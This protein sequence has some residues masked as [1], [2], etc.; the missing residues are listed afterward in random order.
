MRAKVW[1]FLTHKSDLCDEKHGME[2]RGGA[3]EGFN[4]NLIHLVQ[5]NPQPNL[6]WLDLNR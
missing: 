2:F 1:R 5:F 3:R 6:I 4:S